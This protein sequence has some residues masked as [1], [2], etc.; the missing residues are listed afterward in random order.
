MSDVTSKFV[1]LHVA[2]CPNTKN[3]NTEE[4]KDQLDFFQ[5]KEV[6]NNRSGN[7]LKYTIK[8]VKITHQGK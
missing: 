4:E 6:C 7:L 1:F 8:E 3:I 2:V 5:V